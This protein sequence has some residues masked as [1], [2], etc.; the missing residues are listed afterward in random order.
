[1][2]CGA[3]AAVV[4]SLA[5]VA[6]SSMELLSAARGYTQGEALWSKGQKDAMLYLMRYSQTRSDTDYKRFL[7]ALQYRWLAGQL[8]CK[9]TY[10]T[11]I[12]PSSA[13]RLP[14]WVFTNKTAAG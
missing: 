7:A 11:V 12:P 1:M 2:I 3:L 9:W 10:L 8:A 4:A 5:F 14:T 13:T 6:I